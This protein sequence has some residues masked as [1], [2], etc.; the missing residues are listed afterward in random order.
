[1]DTLSLD[2][3]TDDLF[4]IVLVYTVGFPGL[5]SYH[6][7]WKFTGDLLQDGSPCTFEN[8]VSDASVRGTGLGGIGL[9]VDLQLVRLEPE[10]GACSLEDDFL[11]LPTFVY[12]ISNV[13]PVGGVVMAM[14]TIAVLAPWLAVIG[15][16]GCIGTVV[17]AVARK[18]RE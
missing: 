18:R 1:M 13:S 11:L 9:N 12:S 10:S 17:V 5:M 14:N 4:S 3:P 7:E 16:V 2:F 6:S 15:L 8:V